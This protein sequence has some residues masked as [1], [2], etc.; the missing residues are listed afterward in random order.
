MAAAPPGRHLAGAARN[1]RSQRPCKAPPCEQVVSGYP[2]AEPRIVPQTLRSDSRHAVN[3]ASSTESQPCQALPRRRG[4]SI[5]KRRTARGPRALTGAPDRLDRAVRGG[6]SAARADILP[7]RR[8]TGA[9]SGPARP[10]HA[11]KWSS[12][13]PLLNPESSLRRS[14]PTPGT[15]AHAARALNLSPARLS[16][17]VGVG[18]FPSGA[19]LAVPVPS[20]APRIGSTAPFAA[21]AAPPGP[22]SC[23][24]GA[25]LALSAALQGP[26]T[27]AGGLQI[28]P[29]E[30]RIVPQALR[31]DPRNPRACRQSTESQPCQALRRRRGGSISKRRTARGP[32]ALTAPQPAR[33]RRSRRLQAHPGRH[34][35]DATRNWRSQ[36]PCKAP[37]REQVV[38]GYPLLNPES[39]SGA[40]FRLPPP[41]GA[42]RQH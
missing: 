21:A 38:S 9:L 23:R 26:A 14:V 8:E 24:C 25:K 6:C 18:Q 42:C 7:V 29:A 1:W 5:S 28:P 13:Y 34:L 10:R 4:G 27:R 12:G 31:S 17:V 11:T 2:L 35:A 19:P 39:S 22:T 32:R 30:P 40:P 20:R 36:R 3:G 37:P 41:P 15:P 16:G 33:L